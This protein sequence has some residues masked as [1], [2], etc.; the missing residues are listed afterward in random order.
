MTLGSLSRLLKRKVTLIVVIR[1]TTVS[2]SLLFFVSYTIT[3]VGKNVE[4]KKLLPGNFDNLVGNYGLSN[5]EIHKKWWEM[6]QHSWEIY[7]FFS[8]HNDWTT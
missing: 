7:T 3:M 4:I 6:L 1:T 5:K 2:L 8:P